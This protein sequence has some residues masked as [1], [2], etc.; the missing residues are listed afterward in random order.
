MMS[1]MV[2]S[3]IICGGFDCTCNRLCRPHQARKES[4]VTH[5]FETNDSKTTQQVPK[6]DGCGTQESSEPK[7]LRREWQVPICNSSPN[8]TV[9]GKREREVVRL[10][11]E[12]KSNKEIAPLL[13]ITART[14]ETYRSRIMG[15]LNIHCLAQLIRYA[16][17]NG[18]VHF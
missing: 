10:L 9:L 5:N 11:A 2:S 17:Q 14:V 4:R 13:N 6:G 16:V 15:K 3:Q 8:R 7:Y 18:L 1:P 12:G